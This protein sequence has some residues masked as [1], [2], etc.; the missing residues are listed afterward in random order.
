[1]ETKKSKGRLFFMIFGLILGIVI[2]L[3]VCNLKI[4]NKDENNEKN[5]SMSSDENFATYANGV[6]NELG[7]MNEGNVEE[8]SYTPFYLGDM[9][10]VE[11]I[12]NFNIEDIYINQNGE[13]YISF[14]SSKIRDF[15]TIKVFENAIDCGIY[16]VGND[17]SSY[18]IWIIGNDGYLYIDEHDVYEDENGIKFLFKK[19]KDLKNIVS[20]S[21]YMA[22][23]AI[24][25]VCV[26][27]DGNMHTIE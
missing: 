4:E 11:R 12:D 8:Y 16:P 24:M 2:G 27:I 10:R 1:M 20:V 23:D 6:K 13:V 3:F 26:D 25:T 18:L 21:N 14:K 17:G 22:F 7:K 19:Q 9:S 5:L 15:E